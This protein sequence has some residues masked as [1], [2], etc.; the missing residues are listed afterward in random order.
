MAEKTI[1][2]LQKAVDDGNK[3]LAQKREKKEAMAAKLEELKAEIAAE[4]RALDP[5]ETELR[6]RKSSGDMTYIG[7]GDGNGS[8]G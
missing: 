1:E 5:L 8:E 7:L 2:K 6:E 3:S 4:Q